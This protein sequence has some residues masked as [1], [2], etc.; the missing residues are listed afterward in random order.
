MPGGKNLVL[1]LIFLLL[2]GVI[3]WLLLSSFRR[4]ARPAEPTNRDVARPDPGAAREVEVD[5]VEVGR[6]DGPGAA[7]LGAAGAASLAGAGAMGAGAMGAGAMGAAWGASRE[8]DLNEGSDA[9]AAP[10]GVAGDAEADLDALVA[11]DE[12]VAPARVVGD[13]DG[14]ADDFDAGVDG[15]LREARLAD[16]EGDAALAAAEAEAREVTESD[17]AMPDLSGDADD[18]DLPEDGGLHGLTVTD[19]DAA[20]PAV[21]EA[22]VTEVAA[23]EVESS[24]E[25]GVK[26]EESVAAESVDDGTLA[27]AAADHT[28]DDT[29]DLEAESPVGGEVENVPAGGDDIVEAPSY[30]M[31]VESAN[32]EVD[33]SGL[34]VEESAA[35][36]AEVDAAGLDDENSGGIDASG[37]D[38]D[39]DGSQDGPF[40]D[41]SG[42][43]AEAGAV[44]EEPAALGESVAVE[45]SSEVDA[46]DGA[47]AVADG[48]DADGADADAADAGGADADAADAGKVD[49]W[50]AE[51]VTAA[52]VTTESVVAEEVTPEG[53]TSDI[54]VADVSTA[55]ESAGDYQ[56][57]LAAEGSH[58]A[59]VAESWASSASHGEGHDGGLHGES[60]EGGVIATTAGGDS[61]YEHR[62]EVVDGGWSVG[63]AAPI[64]DGCMPLGHPVKGVYALGI[65]Q[66]PGSDWYDATTADVW[67]TDEDAA[68]RAGFRRG[69]G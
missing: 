21:S 63:S 29:A 32:V 33:A 12:Q 23:P 22:S 14:S 31:S 67:F 40:I 48:V 2:V 55:T 66:V 25:E 69:E 9:V 17:Y 27:E 7:T 62:H 26:V 24:G 60:D 51:T 4:P 64:E 19:D 45:E 56:G 20:D 39:L 49:A 1:L 46:P 50:T 13:V 11:V 58:D 57:D 34:D 52:G 44:D 28:A 38:G 59:A 36:F 35:A 16:D 18:F 65:Y 8:E 42:L 41:A 37:L 15:V 5:D 53:L 10:Q 47:G 54:E 68:Q 30:A 3:I 61:A 6:V 43:D